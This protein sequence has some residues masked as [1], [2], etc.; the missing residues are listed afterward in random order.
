MQTTA[1]GKKAETKTETR[2]G[3]AVA[4]D[5]SVS[6]AALPRRRSR[7]GFAPR[8]VNWEGGED[9]AWPGSKG[10]FS[11]RL[12]ISTKLIGRFGVMP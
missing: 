2:A 3:V 1:M 4:E 12:R 11:V 6:L 9:L 10:A 7:A 5:D 8:T